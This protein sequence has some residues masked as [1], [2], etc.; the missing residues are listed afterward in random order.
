MGQEGEEEEVYEEEQ[1]VL[2]GGAS[3]S[4]GDVHV[5]KQGRLWGVCDDAWTIQAAHV[6]CRSVG[7]SRALHSH[8]NSH[9]GSTLHGEAIKLYGLLNASSILKLLKHSYL[10]F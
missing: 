8:T 1:V 4:S 9:F 5:F 10:P 7:F 3:N 2:L 6:V